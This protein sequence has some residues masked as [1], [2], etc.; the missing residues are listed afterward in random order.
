M[1]IEKIK[2]NLET[3]GISC[4]Y[5]E[6]GEEAASYLLRILNGRTIGIGGSKTIESMGLYEK[7]I[8]NNK[9]AWHWKSEDADSARNEAYNAEVYLSSANA[10]SETG[11]IVNIDGRCNRLT[12]TMYN[13]KEVYYIIGKN[14]ICESLE[15]AVW[16]ARNVASPLNARRFGLKTPCASG[17]LKCHDCSSPQRICKEILITCGRPMGMDKMEVIIINEDLGY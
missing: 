12:G 10:I 8:E 14:K 13:S 5:F 15:K 1:D 2:S 11:E 17:E 4:E 9:V 7:L 16:R 3:R 6:T